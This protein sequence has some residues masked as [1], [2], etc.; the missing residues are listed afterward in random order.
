MGIKCSLKLQPL[1]LE[2]RRS[3]SYEYNLNNGIR[4]PSP[5]H[6]DWLIFNVK[7]A[8]SSEPHSMQALR[9]YAFGR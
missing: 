1:F 7:Q 3:K 4:L 6:P 5:L 2:E 9:S 8:L